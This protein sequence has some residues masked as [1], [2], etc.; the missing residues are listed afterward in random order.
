MPTDPG[1]AVRIDRLNFEAPDILVVELAAP[2]GASLPAWSPGAHVDLI[3]PSGTVRQYSLCGDP[4]ERARYKVAVLRELAGRGGSLEL[5]TVGKTGLSL[6]I[7]GPRNHFELVDAARYLFIAGG[8]GVT[9]IL[10]MMRAAEQA[11]RPWRLVYGAQSRARMGFLNEIAERRGGEVTLIPQDEA[12][13]PDL[14]ALLTDVEAGTVIYG[15]GPSGMLKALESAADRHGLSAALHI[16]RFG[17]ADQAEP[18]VHAGDQP[19]EVELRQ[20]GQV[21]QVPS[22]RSLGSVLRDAGI[23]VTFSCEEG[24]CGSCETPV[25]EGI[26]DHRDTILNEEERA[27][28]NIMMVCVGRAR[29]PR[30]VLDV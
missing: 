15:C 4:S 6:E 19:F 29:S 25:L 9:P 20:S 16:E 12:G 28:G 1:L 13:I 18:A 11:G 27:A 10:P 26:P 30:L 21:L 14:D 22:D 3:L 17:P 8:I 23:P 2:D 5:H 24:Y 7:R